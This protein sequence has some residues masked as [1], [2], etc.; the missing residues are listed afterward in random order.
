MTDETTP[1]EPLDPVGPVEPEVPT[2][3]VEPPVPFD[4][5]RARARVGRV[6]GPVG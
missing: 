1:P 6:L 3:S 4:A 2:P 5:R